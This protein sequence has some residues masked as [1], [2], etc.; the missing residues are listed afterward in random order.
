MDKNGPNIKISLDL[1]ENLHTSPLEGVELRVWHQGFFI[2]NLYLA[3]LV[4]KLKSYWITWKF[5]YKQYNNPFVPNAHFL[6][7][8]KTSE[9]RKIF[10]CFQG[11][12]KGCIGNEWVSK[13]LP[14]YVIYVSESVMH[15][16]PP[17]TKFRLHTK[18][19]R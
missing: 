18:S 1:L 12:E 2:Q 4:R 8:L 5:A 13:L 6:Y 15:I 9:N 16:S 3:K 10:W 17:K 11:V 14:I 7:P 19:E